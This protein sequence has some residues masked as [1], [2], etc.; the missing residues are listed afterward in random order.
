MHK[1]IDREMYDGEKKELLHGESVFQFGQR[2]QV[3]IDG[4]EGIDGDGVIGV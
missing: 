2:I 3:A 4:V 1:Y